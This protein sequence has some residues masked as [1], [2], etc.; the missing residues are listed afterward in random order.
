[1]LRQR[2]K[3]KGRQGDT[4]TKR[5]AIANFGKRVAE[6]KSAIQLIM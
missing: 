5:P 6:K 4:E 3:E 1:M 2:D